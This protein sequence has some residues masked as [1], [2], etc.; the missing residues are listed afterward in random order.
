MPGRERASVVFC[1]MAPIANKCLPLLTHEMNTPPIFI[2]SL[3]WGACLASGGERVR[4]FL[5]AGL[6]H[7]GIVEP[8]ESQPRAS[9]VVTTPYAQHQ[10]PQLQP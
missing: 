5:G 7:P 10:Q 3:G 4:G 9:R 1:T 6:T 2:F 8:G